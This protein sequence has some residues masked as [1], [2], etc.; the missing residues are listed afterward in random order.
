MAVKLKTKAQLLDK[1]NSYAITPD[2]YCVLFKERIKN[3]LL[4]C[5]EILHC[6]NNKEFEKELFNDDG[7]INYEGDWSRYHGVNILPYLFLSQVQDSVTNYLCYNV[8]YT[9]QPTYNSFECYMQITFTVL[10]DSEDAIDPTTGIARH[11]LI[12]SIIRERI[13]WSH[14]F[15]TQC[16]LISNKESITD[17]NYVVRTLTFRTTVPN[18]VVRTEKGVTRAINKNVWK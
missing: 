5:P 17:T 1:L 9:E 11:D 10:I 15:N 14:V 13:N 3:N 7:T 16:E 8:N 4:E 6:L 12:G 2:D 18:S